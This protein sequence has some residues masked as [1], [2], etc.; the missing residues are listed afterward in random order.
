[1][2]VVTICDLALAGANAEPLV[3]EARFAD[4]APIVDGTLDDAAWRAAKPIHVAVHQP[5]TRN[6]TTDTI[7]Q[8]RAVR[9]DR[10]IYFAA[11]WRDP[12][13]SDRKEL[14]TYDGRHWRRD[15]HDDEDRLALL[16]PI[17]DSLSWF[18]SGGCGR[19]CHVRRRDRLSL[20]DAPRW[21]KSTLAESQ[22]LDVWHW[23]SVR[24]NALGHADDKFWAFHPPM[25]PRKNGGRYADARDGEIKPAVKNVSA[26]KSGPAFM[27]N[28]NRVPGIA[29]V[30]L[31]S[32]AVPLDLGS[33]EAGDTV[34]GRVLS[35]PTGSQ[36]DVRARGL[37]RDGAWHLELS[38]ALDTTHAD[39]A[40]FRPGARIAFSLAVFDNVPES[41]KQDHGKATGRL[42]LWLR[43]D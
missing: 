41:R 24:S 39:D 29:G 31:A 7:V 34:P 16:F 17:G 26:D 8:L 42:V 35:V 3:L 25:D 14:W 37:H 15:P 6:R 28:P 40:I 1:M 12:T 30:L 4:T 21:Y 19:T 38:R 43:K 5:P 13:D 18:D 36:S 11:Q 2:M 20:D 9:T 33:F 22:R 32:D 27:Q 10:D 23:K